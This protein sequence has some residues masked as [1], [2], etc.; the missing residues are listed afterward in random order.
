[1][2]E[3]LLGSVGITHRRFCTALGVG[4]ARSNLGQSSLDE[5]PIPAL[6]FPLKL[7]SLKW[8]GYVPAQSERWCPLLQSRAYEIPA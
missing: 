4:K 5:A 3:Q 2:K 8:Q 6:G 1:M 7:L